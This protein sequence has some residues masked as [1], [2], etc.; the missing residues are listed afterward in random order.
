MPGA[1]S[2]KLYVKFD[3]LQ[4]LLADGRTKE[5]AELVSGDIIVKC[6]VGTRSEEACILLVTGPYNELEQEALCLDS[7]SKS[8]KLS[9]VFAH[10]THEV[11]RFRFF[12]DIE[13]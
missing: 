1:S 5:I 3:G 2:N 6:N 10:A 12:K 11:Y 13:L 9:W 8:G 7:S 4:L